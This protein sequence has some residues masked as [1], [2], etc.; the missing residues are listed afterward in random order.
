MDRVHA[1]FNKRSSLKVHIGQY[2][3]EYHQLIKEEKAS[4]PHDN[5]DGSIANFMD[6]ALEKEEFNMLEKY[7]R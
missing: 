7:C 5:G 3:D 1:Q 6:T 4:S 2:F